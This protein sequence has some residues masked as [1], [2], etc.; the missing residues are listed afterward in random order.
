MLLTIDIGNSN[1]K[2]AVFDGDDIKAHLRISTD[3]NKTDD[4]YSIYLHGLLFRKKIDPKSVTGAVISSVVPKIT[5]LIEFA[6]KDNLGIEPLVIGPGVKTGLNILLDDPAQL[7]AD[8]VC[9]SVAASN[10]YTPPA[11]IISMGTATAI[12][13][14]D[15]KKNMRGGLIAPGVNISLDALTNSGALLPSVSLDIPK[16][17]IGRNTI[18]CIQSGIVLG[19]ACKIDG[20]IDRIENEIGCECTVIAT[21][22][23]SKNI[24][25]ACKKDIIIDENLIIKGSKLIFERNN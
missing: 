24:I 6:I 14:I 5:P 8:L 16:Y 12:C 9:G 10:L 22:G 18:N 1:I 21:G 11:I 15:E 19:E 13:V 17:T 2:W 3:K 20:L 23:L 4:E 25:P 7:G